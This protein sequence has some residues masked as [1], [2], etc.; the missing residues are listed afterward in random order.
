MI[1]MICSMF[2]LLKGGG[3]LLQVF[4]NGQMLGAGT[5]ALA[6]G[7]AVA[8]LAVGLDQVAVIGGLDG[9]ALVDRLLMV[10]VKGEI[11]GNVLILK[12]NMDFFCS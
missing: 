9:K 4:H 8:G 7:N 3:H 1:C 11:L 12:K 5:L 2:L 6:A 10:V